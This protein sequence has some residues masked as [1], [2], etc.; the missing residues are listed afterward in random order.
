M[1]GLNVKRARVEEC[2]FFKTGFM[3]CSPHLCVFGEQKR[4]ERGEKGG[5]GV[6]APTL[7][8]P[9][10]VMTSAKDE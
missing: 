10:I 6:A 8:S 7:S 9:I 2:N 3:S 1:L 4:S 5:H